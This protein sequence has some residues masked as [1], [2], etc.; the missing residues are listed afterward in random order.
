MTAGIGHR[1]LRGSFSHWLRLRK[2]KICCWLHLLH[3][4]RGRRLIKQQNLFLSPI[5]LLV[6]T[7][8]FQKYCFYWSDLSEHAS[9]VCIYNVLLKL[10]Y[11]SH[12]GLPFSDQSEHLSHVGL[13]FSDQSEHLPHWDLSCSDQSEYLSHR[14]YLILTNQNSEQISSIVVKIFWQII[15]IYHIYCSSPSSDQSDPVSHLVY[16]I[17]TNQSISPILVAGVKLLA[18]AAP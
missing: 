10:L 11:L 9:D 4:L 2:C 7:E 3:L 12:V 16:L 1:F 8:H 18:P 17:L 15:S 6:S 14:V 5:T 13:Q